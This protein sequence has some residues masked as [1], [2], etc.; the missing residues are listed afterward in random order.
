MFLPNDT[1]DPEY[2]TQFGKRK[3]KRNL[4]QEW[5]D[6]SKAKKDGKYEY[7]WN[8]NQFKKLNPDKVDHIMGEWSWLDPFK[9]K[10]IV[11]LPQRLVSILYLAAG[12]C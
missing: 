9:S 2:P 8:N 5:Q 10:D 7:V 11:E 3:D 4:I 1:A 12:S 6:K